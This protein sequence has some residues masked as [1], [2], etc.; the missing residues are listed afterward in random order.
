MTLSSALQ[1]LASNEGE[2]KFRYNAISG[3]ERFEVIATVKD[4]HTMNAVRP[5]H[6]F[7]LAFDLIVI[8]SIAKLKAFTEG[9]EAK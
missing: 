5:E 3:F 6:A 2:L 7:G 1:W 9:V 8:S 4:S